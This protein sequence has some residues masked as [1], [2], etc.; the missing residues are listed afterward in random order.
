MRWLADM[1]FGFNNSAANVNPHAQPSY[2]S[3]RHHNETWVK[4]GYIQIDQSP[5]EFAPLKML[6]EIVTVRVGHREINYG[7][8]HFRR[9][10]NRNAICNGFV[11][12]RLITGV[13]ES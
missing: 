7:D 1:G 13:S 4:D 11:A 8:A 12:G 10:D 6:F 5:I 2:L 9:S 3:S